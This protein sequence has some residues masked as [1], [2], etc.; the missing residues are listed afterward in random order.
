MVSYDIL[1]RE[2]HEGDIVVVKGNGGYGNPSKAME[3][4]IMQK[5]SVRTITGCRNPR[6]KFL[7]VH[8]SEKELEIKK[9]I[10]QAMELKKKKKKINATQIGMI[11]KINSSHNNYCN[12]CIYLGYGKAKYIKDGVMEER[13]GH[14]YL[15]YSDSSDKVEAGLFKTLYEVLS[16]MSQHYFF[17]F[18]KTVLKSPKSVISEVGTINDVE[19][20]IDYSWEKLIYKG[21]VSHRFVF[22]RI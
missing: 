3:V 15:M 5:N 13:I 2:L 22:E 1:G 16:Q 21:K 11:Y 20:D 7:V 14:T 12:Y 19:A 10:L 18:E 17:D 8:P 9:T 4:G 6:D